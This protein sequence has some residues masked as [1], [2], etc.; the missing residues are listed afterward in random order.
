MNN[1]ITFSVDAPECVEC[2]HFCDCKNKKKAIC[3][4][5]YKDPVAANISTG[6]SLPVAAEIM[7]KH[8]YRNVKV[9]EN[10]TVTI[11]LE[12][13][14]KEIETSLYKSLRCEFWGGLINE[15]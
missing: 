3:A 11:D 4:C 9:S 15:L 7:V 10:V 2:A 8:D 12:D 13:I 6:L 1:S 5:T 14:K